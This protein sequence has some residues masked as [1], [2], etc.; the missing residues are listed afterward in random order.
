MIKARWREDCSTLDLYESNQLL[1]SIPY[2]LSQRKYITCAT[3]KF[4]FYC[5]IPLL[6]TRDEGTSTEIYRLI[7][8]TAPPRYRPSSRIPEKL[9]RGIIRGQVIK[10][11]P[12]RYEN[13]PSNDASE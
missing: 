11:L 3:C 12:K 7:C 2:E 13:I 10:K 6:R 9:F 5:N 4:Q 1:V 8:D